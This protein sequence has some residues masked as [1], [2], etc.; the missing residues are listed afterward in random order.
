M[1][2]EIERKF[3]LKHEGWRTLITNSTE[4]KQGYLN[5]DKKRTVR[6]RIRGMEGFLTIKGQNDHLSRE[7]FE[8]TI[9]LEEARKLM[10]LCEKPI[11]E[12]TR[13]EYHT[14]GLVWEIDEFAGENKGLLL[15]EVELQ[16][17]NQSIDLPDW[18]GEEVSTD[19]RFY[20]SSLIKRPYSQWKD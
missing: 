11:I 1:G 3:L 8:Y 14:N 13:Y 19:P 18:I 5:S 4:I 9:P 17:E 20:N 2:L 12:K 16:S 7:E 6:V 10:L 15:A